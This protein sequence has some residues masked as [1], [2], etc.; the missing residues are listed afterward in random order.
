MYLFKPWQLEALQ[1]AVGLQAARSERIDESEERADG[2]EDERVE[3]RRARIEKMRGL[4]KYM[5]ESIK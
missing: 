1:G 2:S 4:W 5:V 3:G